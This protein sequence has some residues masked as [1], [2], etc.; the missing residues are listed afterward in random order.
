MFSGPRA[1][2]AGIARHAKQG[3]HLYVR[4]AF[5]SRQHAYCSGS[6]RGGRCQKRT[7]GT[8]K[9]M[10]PRQSGETSRFVFGTRA[11]AV[12]LPLLCVGPGWVR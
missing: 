3:S 5:R 11:R 12:S 4:R 2:L 6:R 7:T 1:G 9:V 8:P 10:V